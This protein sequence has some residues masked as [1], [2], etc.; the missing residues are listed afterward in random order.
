MSSLSKK[1]ERRCLD[2]AYSMLAIREHSRQE[3]YWKLRKRSWC[4]EPEIDDLLDALEENNILSDERYT[5]SLIRSRLSL[6]QGRL[7]IKQRLQESGVSSSLIV[8]YLDQANINWYTLIH[9]VRVKKCGE[10]LPI[11]FLDKAKLSR[12]LASRGFEAELIREEL[13]L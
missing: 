1:A 5:E 3:L 6:G 10:K 7:K 8:Q 13:E 9:Q 11:E 2:T 4:D 12:F